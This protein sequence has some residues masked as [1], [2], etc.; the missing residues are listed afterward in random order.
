MIKLIIADDHP[1]IINGII[2]VLEKQNEIKL[3]C[4]VN[5][6]EELLDY[7][8]KKKAD[9]V[10][11]DINMPIVNGIEAC[12]VI[13]EKYID[14]KVIAFSQY[15]E[16]RFVKRMM[17]SGAS[18]YILKNSS[19]AEIVSAIKNVHAGLIH[20]SKDLPNI[21]DSNSKKQ[22]INSLFPDLSSREIDVLRLVLNEMNTKE[23]ADKLFI[24]PHT[25]ETHRANLLLKA[26]VKN[27]AGLVKWAIENEFV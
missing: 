21:F 23:I 10:L 15:D 13:N 7:L 18:G 12:K 14:T 26:G 1:I 6:G 3:V 5:N 11:L 9:V 17:K 24:S 22:K 4:Q 2:T 19:A 20:L 27:S 8:S 16:K 25:V